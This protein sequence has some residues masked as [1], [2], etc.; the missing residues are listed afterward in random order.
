MVL[1]SKIRMDLARLAPFC[2]A[3]RCVL[4][5]RPPDASARSFSPLLS[6][7]FFLPSHSMHACTVRTH[8]HSAHAHTCMHACAHI[9]ACTHT[10]ARTRRHE[11]NAPA[12]VREC[13]VR[14]VAPVSFIDTA[15]TPR[16]APVGRYDGSTGE[17]D[18]HDFLVRKT[19]RIR[20][21]T[22]FVLF[23]FA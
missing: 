19:D 5:L 18:V 8:T 6:L 2:W 20:Q 10:Y 4:L 23:C 12:S 15:R 17:N 7:F 14:A 11:H 3:P 22:I 9:Y 13:G 16:V 21:V 1:V